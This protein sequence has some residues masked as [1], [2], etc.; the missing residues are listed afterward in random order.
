[1]PVS[2]ADREKY[3]TELRETLTPDTEILSVLRHCSRSGMSR[4]IDF[5]YVRTTGSRPGLVRLTWQVQQ[6]LGMSFD[7]VHDGVKVSGCG[8]D[9]GFHVA[10]NLFVT[11]WPDLPYQNHLRHSWI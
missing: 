9:M 3:I 10:Y 1:M 7:R 5:F 8:M 6:I 11:L 2:K 4:S